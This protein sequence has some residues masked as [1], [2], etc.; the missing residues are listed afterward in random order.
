MGFYAYCTMLQAEGA[1]IH[2]TVCLPAQTGKF[3]VLL[4]RSP[5]VDGMEHM[6]DSEIAGLMLEKYQLWLENGYAVAAQHCRGCGRSTGDC[7]PYIYEREDGLLL[8]DWVRAQPF[9]N[10][11]LYLSGASYTASVHY[12]TAP[13]APDIK[14]AV[15]EVQDCERYNCNYR[16]GFYRSSLHGSWYVEMYKKKTIRQKNFVPEAYQTL[17]LTEFSKTVLGEESE[18]FDQILLHP[19]SQDPFWDTR[20]GGG[21]ARGA[22]QHANIPILL[23]TGFYDIYTGGV[24]AMWRGMDSATRAQSALVVH[25]YNHGG[26]SETQPVAFPQGEMHEAFGDYPIRW[27]NY[28]RGLEPAP[29]P[30]G[31]VTY[32]QLF[33]KG[34]RTDAFAQ[35]AQTLEFPFGE[36]MRRYRYN[37]YAPASFRGGLSNNFGGTAY[38]DPPNS[39]YDILSFYTPAFDRDCAVKGQMTARLW[40]SSSCPDTCFYLRVSLETPEGDYGLRD[41]IQAVS[42]FQPDYVPGTEVMLKFTF[43][44]HAFVVAKGQRL[45]ID[46]SSSAFPHFVRHTNQRG[47]FAL[48]TTA[49]IADNTVFCDRSCLTV[50]IE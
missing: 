24:F 29:V 15:L 22:V 43:D 34:W 42:R 17:P 1:L 9:Y 16:N 48:Q 30:L 45:R 38:Q 7:V 41:D 50:P 36:G 46:V 37:P 20:L 5:Y 3:P 11:E 27:L 23:V 2:T 19:D 32:Y 12:V 40:A 21:E 4:N 10:G 14:G 6:E 25:P 33:G 18:D 49:A 31:Q 35:P 44:P 8:Q 47:P 26:K 39:R 13:F 28:V